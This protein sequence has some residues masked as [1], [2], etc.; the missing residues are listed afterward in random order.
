LERRAAVRGCE[1]EIMP[2]G[3]AVSKRFGSIW[4]NWTPVK[5]PAACVP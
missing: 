1:I 5:M 3:G 2:G 4:L